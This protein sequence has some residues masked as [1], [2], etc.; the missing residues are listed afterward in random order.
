MVASQVVTST[1]HTRPEISKTYFVRQ[2][3]SKTAPTRVELDAGI[4]LSNELATIQGFTVE[5]TVKDDPAINEVF[6]PQRDA[7]RVSPASSL[8]FYTSLNSVDVR[9]ILRRGDTG[10]LVFLDDGDVGGRLM[11]VFPV[12]VQVASKPKDDGVSQV[13]VPFVITSEPAI[14]VTVPA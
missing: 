8:T 13:M 12:T 14:D 11:D 6:V 7:Q 1:R 2:V 9:R 4:D 5:A 3:A 10:F